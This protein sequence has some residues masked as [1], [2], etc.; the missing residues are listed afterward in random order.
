MGDGSSV[1][2]KVVDDFLPE[3]LLR[4]ITSVVLS[5]QFPWYY[6]QYILTDDSASGWQ[7]THT[8]VRDG[9]V[10]STWMALLDPFLL[11]LGNPLITRA[12]LNLNYSECGH[13]RSGLHIDSIDQTTSVFY[14]NT[15]NGGTEFEDGTTVAGVKNRMVTFD[16]NLQHTGIAHTGDGPRVVLNLNYSR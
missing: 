7:L 10:N 14:L 3:R 4:Q 13:R 6:N 15:T 11:R 12:K 16:S 8:F 5:D 2:V 1:S 9:K